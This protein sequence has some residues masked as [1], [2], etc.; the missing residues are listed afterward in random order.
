MNKSP[1]LPPSMLG[2]TYFFENEKN[3]EEF[4]ENPEKYSKFWESY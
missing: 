2:K 1:I 4:R 3:L